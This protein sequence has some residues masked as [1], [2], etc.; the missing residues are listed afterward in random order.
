[1]STYRGTIVSVVQCFWKTKKADFR[2]KPQR[3][4][5]GFNDQMK[6]IAFL[7]GLAALREMAFAFGL[8][9]SIQKQA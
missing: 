9:I 6:W 8:C 7:Y 2:A 1:M 5:E 4:Q 3:R